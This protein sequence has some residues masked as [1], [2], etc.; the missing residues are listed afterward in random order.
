MMTLLRILMAIVVGLGSPLCCCQAAMITGAVTG[1]AGQCPMGEERATPS[2]ARSSCCDHCRDEPAAGQPPSGDSDS[3]D[4]QSSPCDRTPC[5]DCPGCQGVLGLAR[6]D[7]GGAALKSLALAMTVLFIAPPVVLA[8]VVYTLENESPP[9]PPDHLDC[10]AG[11][12]VLLRWHCALV[13]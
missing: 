8:P 12:R 13:I 4:H 1:T 2:S 5:N 11:G 7:D 9:Q 6:L 3:S 10:D